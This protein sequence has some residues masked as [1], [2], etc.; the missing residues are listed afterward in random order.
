MRALDLVRDRLADVVEQR[1]ALR[2]LHVRVELGR[3][4]PAEVDDLER[5]L[6]DVLAV[7]R[8]VVEPAEELDELLVE[9]AAVRLE[10]GL[11]A[12]LQDV[13]VDLRLRLVVHLLDP[14]RLD[15][16]VLDELERGHLRDLAADRVEGR[17]HDRLRR[18]VDDHVDAGQVLERADVASLA[19]DDPALH[20]VGGKLDQR[21]GRLGGMACRD[22]LERV[23]DEVAARR[24]ASP[25][26]SSSSCRT[27]RA[28][29]WRTSSS[30]WASSRAFA[31]LTVMPETR[32]SSSSSRC[33][34]SFRSSWSSLTCDLAVGEALL[35]TL[36]L[37]LPPLDLV[38]PR[39]DTLLDLRDPR[40]LLGD[41]ALDLS[42]EA[43][44][45]L[46]GFD[47]RLT[48]D[49]LGLAARLGDAR[50]PEQAQGDEH[51]RTP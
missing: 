32:S 44:G 29:S 39:E 43:D 7:A 16:A 42:S 50:P 23:G 10:D 18:V 4:Q 24:F 35:A 34:A 5:V 36:D 12:G 26:A 17:E 25:C 40:T 14:R 9:L 46:A 38:L 48:T 49:R 13:L 47:L 27:R 15:A 8:A 30:D 41:L 37:L 6:E 20:V 19:A 21:R 51:E 28:R 11:L 45:L 31:S 1:R 2:R 3:H 33:F 22:P